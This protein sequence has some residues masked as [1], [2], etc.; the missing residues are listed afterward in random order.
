MSSLAVAGLKPKASNA[1]NIP[2]RGR[3]LNNYATASLSCKCT[4]IF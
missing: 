1:A 4:M 2:Y 3:A